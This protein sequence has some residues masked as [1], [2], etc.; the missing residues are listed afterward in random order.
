MTVSLK[1][2][3][4]NTFSCVIQKHMAVLSTTK[5]LVKWRYIKTGRVILRFFL[6]IWE[7]RFTNIS[8][9]LFSMLAL[10]SSFISWKLISP[11]RLENL[12]FKYL[13]WAKK[14]C[15][16]IDAFLKLKKNRDSVTFKNTNPLLLWRKKSHCFCL[17]NSLQ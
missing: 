8:S 14:Q 2:N 17:L 12:T 10:F 13:F 1:C 9:K 3:T 15:V 7:N 6:F 4:E 16:W 11:L 5:V